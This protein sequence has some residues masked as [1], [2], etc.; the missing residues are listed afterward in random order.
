MSGD[1]GFQYPIVRVRFLCLCCYSREQNIPCIFA[2]LVHK[3]IFISFH[4]GLLDWSPGLVAVSYRQV[5]LD[6]CCSCTVLQRSSQGFWSMNVNCLQQ[7]ALLGI[8]GYSS[9]HLVMQT[10][11]GSLLGYL[12]RSCCLYT[13]QCKG[14]VTHA[15]GVRNYVDNHMIKCETIGGESPLFYNKGVAN[16]CLCHVNC[17]MH[18]W[19]QF[20]CLCFFP[21]LPMLLSCSDVGS[22]VNY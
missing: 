15:F 9:T 16:T 4:Q 6:S 2:I 17:V 5:S 21:F 10:S 11:N 8:L 14:E 12:R 22:T 20:L 19:R 7:C 3:G 13:V 1:H 18:G